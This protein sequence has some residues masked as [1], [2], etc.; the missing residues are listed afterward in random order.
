[1]SLLF[2]ICREDF[3]NLE[4]GNNLLAP[5]AHVKCAIPVDTAIFKITDEIGDNAYR[6]K[7]E[8]HTIAIV[9]AEKLKAQHCL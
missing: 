2:S 7:L 6:L 5:E 3:K 9:V 4:P 1:M 8:I